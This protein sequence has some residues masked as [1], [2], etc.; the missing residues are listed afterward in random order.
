MNPA[1]GSDNLYLG[2]DIGSVSIK[3]VIMDDTGGTIYTSYCET[4]GRPLDIA[5]T[6]FC[7]I[8][9]RLGLVYFSGIYITGSGKSLLAGPLNLPT[10]NEIVSHAKASWEAFPEV[11]SIIEIGG[12]DSKFIEIA[13]L[14]DGSPFIARHAFNGLCSAG[15][16]AFLD[17]QAER[18]GLSIDKFSIKAYQ[19]GHVPHIAGRCSVFAKTDMIHLQQKGASEDDIAAGLCHALAR[20]YIATLCRGR[21][22]D[23]PV[24]FQ[25]GLASNKGMIRA[26]SHVLGIREERLLVPKDHKIMGAIGSAIFARQK[27]L[28]TG[29]PLEKILIFLNQKE[30]S[31]HTAGSKKALIR[32]LRYMRG[33]RL[34]SSNHSEYAYLGVDVGSVTTKAVL[35]SPDGGILASGCVPTKARPIDATK[36]ALSIIK[37]TIKDGPMVRGFYSTGSGRYLVRDIFGADASVDEISAQARAATDL[38]GDIDTIIEIGGQDS[39]FIRIKDGMI[40][41]FVMNRVC[42]AGTGSFLEEQADRLA[43]RIDKEFEEYAFKG[44]QPVDLG[45]RCTVFMDSDLIHHIQQGQTRKNL[46]AGLAYSIAQNYLDNVVGSSKTGDHI[47]FQ[48]GVANNL[49][50]HVAFES[51]LGRKIEIH[52]TP[53]ISGALGAALVARDEMMNLECKSRFVGFEALDQPYNIKTFTCTGCENTCE[54]TK[55][56]NNSGQTSYFGSICGVYE[57]KKEE[58]E[59]VSSLFS[60]RDKLLMEDCCDPDTYPDVTRGKIGI[61]L[62]LLMYEQLPFW[63]TFFRFLGFETDISGHTNKDIATLGVERLPVEACM[64]VRLIYG[65]AAYLKE[66]GVGRIFIPHTR[67]IAPDGEMDGYYLCPYSQGIPYIVRSN[68][69]IETVILEFPGN[70]CDRGWINATSNTLGIPKDE[71]SSALDK[72]IEA[73]KNFKAMCREHGEKILNK[74]YKEDKRGIVLIGRPYNLYDRYINMDLARHIAGLGIIPIPMDFLPLEKEKVPPFL[75]DLHWYMGRQCIKAANAV[76]KNPRLSCIVLTNFGCGPDGFIAQYL[77]SVLAHTP[78]M[79]LEFDENRADTG[80]VTRLEAFVR[81]ISTHTKWSRKDVFLSIGPDGKDRPLK[82]YRY[83]VQY[84]SD[85]AYAFVG[86]LKASGCHAELLPPTD[87]TSWQLSKRYAY[88][89]ECHPYHSV[90]G[91]LLKLTMRKDFDPDGA[92][93]YSPKYDGPCLLTQYGTAMKL[94]LERLNMPVR[95]IDIG[96]TSVMKELGYTYPLYLARGAYAIDRLFKWATEIRPYERNKGDVNS[97]HRQNMELLVRRMAQRQLDA[98]IKEAVENM[99]AVGLKD[100]RDRPIIGIA[101]D[102]YTRLNEHANF[103]LYEKLEDMGFEVWPSALIMDLVL[104]GYEQRFK[105]YQLKGERMKAAGAMMWL[106][107]ARLLRKS[108]DRYFPDSIRTPQESP[109]PELYNRISP[110]INYQVDRFVSLNINR[111]GEFYDK[112]ACGVLNVMCPNCM[113]GTLSEAFFPQ[114][115]EKYNNLPIESLM[116][117]DQQTTNNINR[118]EAFEYLVKESCLLRKGGSSPPARWGI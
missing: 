36:N 50:V 51:I 15:T 94:I 8:K 49:A 102:I 24:V 100:T 12:Q 111:I 3:S 21:L 55:I 90:L 92:V 110:Y 58:R 65:H 4:Q 52:P 27:P 35:I 57:K 86:A 41:N 95:L 45:S 59:E 98:G 99:K 79:L 80:T 25:G 2:L 85:H 33:G 69:D 6:L 108:I 72:G 83:Y 96:N 29:F 105:E 13:R 114:L 64:P 1:T 74:L 46:C 81:N 10:I 107:A 42:A 54:I 37:E 84:F 20:N 17:R 73:I 93:Y 97:V 113:I 104:L 67:K 44:R 78:H 116:F 11:K 5:K 76:R 30:A 71:I 106:P 22:P 77:E 38:S 63:K 16:G 26:F 103:G 34:E 39:K 53:S 91:D 47:V 19:A 48:G 7:D 28:E 31:E 56:R 68:L 70:S 75:D 32:P 23:M 117:E 61:P 118:L 88:G 62:G 60:L 40:E 89:H 43:I 14:E 109:F 66:K 18:L 115:R 87:K 112:S 101:G 82:D 9:E